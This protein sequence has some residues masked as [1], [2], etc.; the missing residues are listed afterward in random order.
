LKD[1]E[2]NDTTEIEGNK[3]TI[4]IGNRSGAKKVA[5]ILHGINEC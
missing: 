5:L 2:E 4:D 3:Q 1:E